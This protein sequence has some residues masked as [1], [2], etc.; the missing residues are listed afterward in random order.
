MGTLKIHSENL[1]PLLKRWLYSDKDIF[2]RELVSNACDAIY[3][4]K[5]LRDH[6]EA[7]AAEETPR[8]DIRVDREA[9]TLTFT[10][11]GVGMDAEEVERYICQLAFSGAE[12]FLKNYQSD[13]ESDQMIG[14]FGLG[15][16]SAYM[17]ST[18]VEIRSLS[19]KPE[20]Q[21]VQWS[22]DGGSEYTLEPGTRTTRGTE[23][24]LHVSPEEEEYLDEARIRQ[25]LERYC[26]FLPY[27]IYLNDDHVN[28]ETPLWIK[29]PSECEDKDYLQFYRHLYPGQ[30]DPL[31]WVHL[32]VDYPFH[33]KGILYFPKMEREMDFRSHTVKLFCNRVFVSDNCK[34]LLP[35]YLMVL[36]GAIDCPDIPLNVSRSH[37]QMDRTVRQLAGHISKKVSDALYSHF[38]ADRNEF[39]KFWPDVSTVVK[40][41]ALQDNKFYERVKPM[42]L[43][44]GSEG[45]WLTV[46]EYLTRNSEK[47][48]GKILYTTDE[49]HGAPVLQLYR[50]KGVELLVADSP[51]DAYLIRFLEDKLGTSKF[52]RIDS[53]VDEFLL[54]PTR[55]KTVLDA[56]GK[57]EAAH[58]ADLVRSKLGDA[59]VEVEAKS[60]ATESLPGF[61]TMEEETRRLRDY[62]RMINPSESNLHEN[63][64]GKRT[65]VVNTN[66][67]LFTSLIKLDALDP[68]LTESA[69]KYVYE[70]SLLSQR[71]LSPEQWNGFIQRGHEVLQR[72]TE[73]AVQS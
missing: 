63:M 20:A 65:F 7:A 52:Q 28:H 32:N 15:F 6:G 56:E 13:K 21:P 24:I 2:V 44:K 72:L 31:F 57:T 26:A 51:I 17:V 71:E 45:D 35:E 59:M 73:R 50:D 68:E 38:N 23:I 42:L 11:N 48:H 70:L 10:D 8:I 61:V 55:E 25:I 12:E 58:L 60:L 1:L 16:Y 3:K 36:R 22:C 66:H 46:E 43:W 5:V 47:T 40:L 14:H 62:M 33:L 53:A 64:L 49:A 29:S 54:D 39:I 9:K 18:R 30:P 69:V 19:F 34:D 27:P 67:P 41:G 4:L 37:L